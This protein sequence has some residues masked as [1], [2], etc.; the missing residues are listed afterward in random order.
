MIDGGHPGATGLLCEPI[1]RDISLTDRRKVSE[2]LDSWDL[3]RRD[4]TAFIAAVEQHVRT[5]LHIKAVAEQSSA[6]AVKKN[7]RAAELAAGRLLLRLQELD[8][9]A[10]SYWRC[11]QPAGIDVDHPERD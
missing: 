7:L 10:T 1:V 11:S 6:A 8:A 4:D 3:E 9:T 2:W 5:Y